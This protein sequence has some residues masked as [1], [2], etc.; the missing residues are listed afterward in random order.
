MLKT[1]VERVQHFAGLGELETYVYFPE[2][3]KNIAQI[4]AKEL[5]NKGYKVTLSSSSAIVSWKSPEEVVSDE[6]I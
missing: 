4:V 6:F 5:R 1:W 3:T 2:E